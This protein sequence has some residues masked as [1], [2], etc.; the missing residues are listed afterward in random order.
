SFIPIVSHLAGDHFNGHA[1]FNGVIIYIC[2]L[3]SDHWAF[4]E[5]YKCYS[6]RSTAVITAW[7]FVNGCIGIHF[8]FTAKC[9][10]VFGFVTAVWAYVA[11][12]KNLIIAMGANFAYQPVT[13]F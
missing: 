10:E 5:F 9:I 2:Q 4:I 12:R 3:C 11:R 6:V 1:D 7:G 8:T 13:L